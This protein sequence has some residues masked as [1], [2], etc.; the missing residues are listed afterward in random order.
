MEL[1]EDVIEIIIFEGIFSFDI[2]RAF[3]F[4]Y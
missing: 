1:R 4:N 3:R 2:G